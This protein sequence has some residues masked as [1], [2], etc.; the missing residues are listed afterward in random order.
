[1][2]LRPIT[3]ADLAACADVFY[4]AEDELYAR[5]N[6]PPLPRNAPALIS[7]FAHLVETDP[8]LCWLAADGDGGTVTGFGM[9]VERGTLRYLAFLFV[10]P[11][12]QGHGVGRALLARCL[13][14]DGPRATCIE[15][16]QP[17]SAALYASIGLL[18]LLPIY[19]FIGQPRE[20]LAGLPPGLAAEPLDGRLD[21]LDALDEQVLGFS[22][23]PDHRAWLAWER[24]CFV[25]I[26]ERRANRPVGYAYGHRSGRLGP[27][28]SL[29][30]AHVLPLVGETMSRVT[31]LDAWQVLVPGV[32]SDAFIGLLGAGLR[33]DGPPAVLCADGLAVDHAR[34]LP[35]TFA[36]P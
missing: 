33:I 19:T 7:L 24:Q 9:A 17:V 6:L 14:P 26:D 3:D 18:P 32:A 16:V 15:A 29:D 35:A 21:V 34:Y 30:P 27:V 2:D 31:P 12:R 25:A 5:L 23:R 20:A 4:A 11:G 1:M 8:G 28:L 10:A 36:L 13:P 22:R